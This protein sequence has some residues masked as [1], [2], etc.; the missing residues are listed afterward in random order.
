MN[1]VLLGWDDTMDNIVKRI[2]ETIFDTPIEDL[3]IDY[4]ELGL[5]AV[6]SSEIVESIPVVKTIVA[7]FKT[8]ISIRESFFIKKLLVFSSQIFNGE[9]SESEIK[10][11]Q[12]AIRNQEPWIKKEI[13]QIVVYLDRFDAAYKA[14]MLANL[15]IAFVNRLIAPDKYIN[16]LA[17]I[18]KWQKYDEALLETLYTEH[19]KGSGHNKDY[20]ILIDAASKQRLEALGVLRVKREVLCLLDYY[21]EDELEDEQLY[22]LEEKH[23]LTYEGI[24]MSEI[25]FTGKVASE[26]DDKYFNLSSI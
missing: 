7:L 9:I 22:C 14:K 13:E 2:E 10:K 3:T 15:Y 6:T 16:M 20:V 12:E 5:D 24:I 8:G 17:I 21:D 11:R 19:K 1:T 25:I 26:F 18:D 23:S 4:L